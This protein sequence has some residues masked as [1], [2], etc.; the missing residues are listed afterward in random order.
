MMI[1]FRETKILEWE[2]A[3]SIHRLTQGSSP[4][5]TESKPKS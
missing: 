5:C 2:M 4:S 3:Q 1:D